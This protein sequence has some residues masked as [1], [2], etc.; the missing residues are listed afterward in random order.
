MR[1]EKDSIRGSEI[2]GR[3]AET[4][5]EPEPEGMTVLLEEVVGGVVGVGAGRLITCKG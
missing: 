4:E 2:T 3:G 5:T 1:L